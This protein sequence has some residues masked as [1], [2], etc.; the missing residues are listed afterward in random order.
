MPP[1]SSRALRDS[2][3]GRDT[4]VLPQ[5]HGLQNTWSQKLAPL[6]KVLPVTIMSVM[7]NEQPSAFVKCAKRNK[8]NSTINFT[9]LPQRFRSIENTSLP[10]Y[11]KVSKLLNKLI[12]LF[13]SLITVTKNMKRNKTGTEE[14]S[15]W[16]LPTNGIHISGFPHSTEQSA[17]GLNVCPI[18]YRHWTDKC[19][20]WLSIYLQW[21]ITDS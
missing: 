8:E 5:C 11:D 4:R 6:A 16:P 19:N 17:A 9:L 15:K 14:H 12:F 1:I 2:N 10:V 13:W 20:A 7:Y 18:T 3:S 21:H